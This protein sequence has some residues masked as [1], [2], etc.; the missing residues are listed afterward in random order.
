MP[1]KSKL[2]FQTEYIFSI[3]NSINFD[4]LTIIVHFSEQVLN[5]L[6]PGLDYK[7]VSEGENLAMRTFTIE[8]SIDGKTFQGVGRS[9]KDAKRNC[10]V[11][12]LK[13]VKLIYTL[14]SKF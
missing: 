5:Q 2:K 6:K 9:K 13:E 7:V 8:I 11:E 3:K 10:A 1:G 4:W 14:Q 12:A